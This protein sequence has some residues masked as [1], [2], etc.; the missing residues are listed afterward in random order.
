ML[1]R[2]GR[3]GGKVDPYPRSFSSTVRSGMDLLSKITSGAVLPI[4]ALPSY[5]SP[6]KSSSRLDRSLRGTELQLLPVS[7]NLDAL[8]SLLF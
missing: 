7:Q 2:Y 6:G 5:P 3:P 1:D 8:C 4:P